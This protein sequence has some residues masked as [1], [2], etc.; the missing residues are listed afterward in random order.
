MNCELE[1]VVL[2]SGSFNPFHIG[3]LEVVKHLSKRFD[4]VYV[5]VS[6]QNPLKTTGADNF[7]ERLENVKRV[8]K[9]ENLTNVFVEDIEKNIT[10]PYYTL[11]TLDALSLK[12][13]FELFSL[14]VGGDCVETFHQWYKWEVILNSYGLIVIPRKGYDVKPAIAELK[15]QGEEPEYWHLTV[16]NVDVPEISSSKIREKLKNGEDVSHLLP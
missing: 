7:N 1:E 16:L 12:Y 14:C 9:N 6:V 8:I 13:P 2:Y 10:P 3:H 4:K 15:K 11:K 5:V